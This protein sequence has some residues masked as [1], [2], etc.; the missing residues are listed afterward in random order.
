MSKKK[1][2]VFFTTVEKKRRPLHP[3]LIPLAQQ[4]QRKMRACIISQ[5]ISIPPNY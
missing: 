2:E 3:L 4:N 1:E 5:E